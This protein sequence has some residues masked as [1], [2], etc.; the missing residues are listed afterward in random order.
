MFIF[1]RIFVEGKA[2]NMPV[3]KYRDFHEYSVLWINQ[4]N[5]DV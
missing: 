1:V 5:G 4:A 2:I 3:G